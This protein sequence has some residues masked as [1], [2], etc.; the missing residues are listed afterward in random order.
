MAAQ[1]HFE[2][3]QGP[4]RQWRWRFRAAN[5]EIIG[6]G[7]GYVAHA[8]CLHAVALLKR[9]AA[10]APV[11]TEQPQHYSNALAKGLLANAARGSARMT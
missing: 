2:I 8:D 10:P 1:P 6:S 9:E 7:E 3:Y 5:G 4:D 11:Y